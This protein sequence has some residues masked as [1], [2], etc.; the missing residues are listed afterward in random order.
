MIDA[1][2]TMKKYKVSD[3]MFQFVQAGG[4]VVLG[5]TFSSLVRPLP[6]SA[7]F[8]KVWGLPWKTGVEQERANL[9]K[10]DGIGDTS[11]FSV[12]LRL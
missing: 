7:Y 3:Q 6:L 8:D 2:P 5:G 4:T 9:S 11:A 10:G 12:T 1:G